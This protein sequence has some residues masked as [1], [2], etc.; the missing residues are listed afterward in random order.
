MEKKISLHHTDNKLGQYWKTRPIQKNSANT[1]WPSFFLY[2]PRSSFFFYKLINKIVINQV[3]SY[4][5]SY[6]SWVCCIGPRPRTNTAYLGP[7]TGPIRNYLINN[8]IWLMLID[9]TS[10]CRIPSTY[11]AIESD[12]I[13]TLTPLASERDHEPTPQVRLTILCLRSRN[14]A[15]LIFDCFDYFCDHCFVDWQFFMDIESQIPFVTFGR[16]ISMMLNKISRNLAPALNAHDTSQTP[17]PAKTFDSHFD[18]YGL[19]DFSKKNP[20]PRF[21]RKKNILDRDKCY[22]VLCK[23]GE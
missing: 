6:R 19:E 20:G 5:S 16:P 12:T 10:V 4:W 2:W 13:C 14:C 3:I 23:R 9:I 11:L 21:C 18:F 7:V 15:D 1:Y 17:S 22:S 8:I